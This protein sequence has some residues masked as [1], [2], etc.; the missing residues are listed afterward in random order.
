MDR[1]MM[2]EERVRVRCNG[3]AYKLAGRL[4]RGG[5]SSG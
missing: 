3:G 2:I 4:E 5:G 1:W